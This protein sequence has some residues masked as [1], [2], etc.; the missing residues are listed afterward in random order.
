[1]N[2]R[3]RRDN[4]D[5]TLENLECVLFSTKMNNFLAKC[6]MEIEPQEFIRLYNTLKYFWGSRNYADLLSDA[7][8]NLEMV[9]S[10]RLYFYVNNPTLFPSCTLLHFPGFFAKNLNK[11]IQTIAHYP[12]L[13]LSFVL[14]RIHSSKIEFDDYEKEFIR[15]ICLKFGNEVNV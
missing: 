15:K 10:E 8:M 6:L 13:Y 2:A 1:M 3:R 7:L 9:Y 5:N 14:S 11:D 4:F 12:A